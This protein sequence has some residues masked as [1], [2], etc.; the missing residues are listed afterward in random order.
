MTSLL[1]F[2]TITEFIENLN[3]IFGVHFKELQLYNRLVEKTTISH[4]VAIQKHVDLFKT[5]C[6]ENKEAIINQ[7]DSLI[8][9]DTISY[10]ERVFI[11]LTKIL[12]KADDSSKKVIW[13]HILIISAYTCPELGT[14]DILKQEGETNNESDFLSNMMSEVQNIGESSNNPMEA[15]TQM[16]SNGSFNNLVQGMTSGLQNGDLDMSKMMGSVTNMM[17]QMGIDKN[18]EMAGMMQNLTGMMTKMAEGM[19][20][21]QENNSTDEMD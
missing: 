12:K 1:A 18:P 10:S 4:K 15:I 20:N 13:K 17:S 3:E 2:N 5:W 8:K 16:M 6:L 19:N 21:N 14:K 11:N 9:V 7:N